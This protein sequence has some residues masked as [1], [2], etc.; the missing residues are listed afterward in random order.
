MR[1][2]DEGI[3]AA[4]IDHTSQFLQYLGKSGLVINTKIKVQEE[5]EYDQSKSIILNN[6]K[7]LNVSHK[8]AANLLV[9]KI[10]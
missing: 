2:G 3:I 8:V 1:A 7:E 6:K 9:R 5:V 10:S 4:V